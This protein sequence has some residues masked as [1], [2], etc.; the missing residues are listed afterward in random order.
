MFESVAVCLHEILNDLLCRC[1]QLLAK[2]L[3]RWTVL[4]GES[5]STVMWVVYCRE[6]AYQL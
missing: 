2:N 3:V 1:K 6:R 5:I 4:Q